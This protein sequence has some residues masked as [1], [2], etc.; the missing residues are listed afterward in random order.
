MDPFPNRKRKR[1]NILGHKKTGQI[2]Q[3]KF[4]TKEIAVRIAIRLCKKTAARQLNPEERG[5]LA[6]IMVS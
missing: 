1:D 6:S 4:T 2:R 3:L 5:R